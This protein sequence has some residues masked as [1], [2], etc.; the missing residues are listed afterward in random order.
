MKLSFIGGAAAALFFSLPAAQAHVTLATGQAT[1]GSYYMAVVRVPHGCQGSD[2]TRLRVRIPEGVLAVKP[3]PKAGWKTDIVQGKYDQP[4]TLHGAK[5]DQ[6]VREVSWSGALPDA[7]YDE[8]VFRA[9][10][11]S[12]LKAGST[13]YFPVVQECAQGV[14]RW[15]NTSGGEE[16]EGAAPRVK[17]VAPAAAAGHHH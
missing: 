2:T 15:I 10:L 9:F 7:Y 12:S 1:V 13:L 14:D 16:A 3:Q 8:F 11:S 6:G 5:L 17:L 4:Q